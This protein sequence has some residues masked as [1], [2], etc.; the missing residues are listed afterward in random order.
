MMK[1]R[2]KPVHLVLDSLPAHKKAIVRD[3]VAATAG[4]VP[5]IYFRATPPT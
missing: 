2:R 3:Y 5:C 1:Y 4:R